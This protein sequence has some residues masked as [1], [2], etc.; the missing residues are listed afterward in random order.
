MEETELQ[1]EQKF[2]GPPMS[3]DELI[4]RYSKEGNFRARVMPRFGICQGL[5]IHPDGTTSQK[6]R[7]I[8]DVRV[9]G[10]NSGTIIPERVL[11]PS[12]NSLERWQV[13]YLA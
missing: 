2:V 12:F 8:D 11:L 13:R 6:I 1:A 9:A 7:C 10:I 4:Q 5:K 3:K